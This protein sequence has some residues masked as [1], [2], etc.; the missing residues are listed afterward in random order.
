MILLTFIFIPLAAAVLS[1]LSGRVRTAG[2]TTFLGSLLL[3][4]FAGCTAA[5]IIHSSGHVLILIPHWL[6]VDALGSIFLL[7]VSFTAMTASLFSIGY[8]HFT[9]EQSIRRYYVNLNLFIFSMII[10]PLIL[11][12]NIVWLAVEFTTLFSVLLVGFENTHKALEAAWKY[13][14]LTLMGASV[15][16]LGFLM[17][18]WAA[19]QGGASQHTW[20][21]LETAAPHMPPVILYAAFV[22]ILVGLGAKI[23]LVPLH[24]WLPDAHS[25]APAPVCALL[26]GIETSIVLYVLLRI[27]PIVSRVPSIHAQTWLL[28]FGLVSAG[29]ASFLLIGVREY[30][31]LFAFSTVEHMGILLTAAG[32]SGLS[33]HSA[34]LLQAIGHTVTKALCFYAA[35]GVL[36][37]T[38]VRDIQSVRA[39]LRRAPATGIFLLLGGLAIAGAPPFA[40]FPGELSILKAAV[41]NGAY[42]VTALLALF[43]VIAFFAIMNHINRLVFATEAPGTGPGE[44]PATPKPLP[45]SLKITFVLAAI[46][47]VVLG[48]YIPESLQQ[49]LLLAAQVMGD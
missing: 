22:L 35:G 38:G 45:V 17:L 4:I 21:A 14:V 42:L 33:A 28:V 25:Q 24:T 40:V 5:K 29:T 48:I 7:L 13:V 20:A 11:E 10:I 31:R 41:H 30:K 26:S 43:I 27:L 8:M 49:L 37:A 32:L 44:I 15:A 9:T 46:P 36:L 1:L 34:T 3:L 18:Y 12:P 47:V 2:G 39:L 23:G 19:K 16:L 6:G